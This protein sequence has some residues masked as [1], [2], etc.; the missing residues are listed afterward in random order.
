MWIPTRASEETVRVAESK[1]GRLGVRRMKIKKAVDSVATIASTDPA[2]IERELSKLEQRR[3]QL[4]ETF[5]SATQNAI[6]ASAVRREAI[7]ANRDQGTRDMANA[8]VRAAEERRVALDDAL[9]ALD[10]QISEL[11]ARFSETKDN[12]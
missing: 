11:T 2:A 4:A 9:R 8:K 5:D 12:A 1:A 6:Q 7:I 3:A 10:Q